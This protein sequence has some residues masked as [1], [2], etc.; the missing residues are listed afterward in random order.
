[1]PAELLNSEWIRGRGWWG[2]WPRAFVID[3]CDTD[4]G[5]K[6]V[7]INTLNSAGFYAGDVK[8]LVLA[9]EDMECQPAPT[10]RETG[11]GR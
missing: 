3:V 1:M 9:L 6:T 5:P 7:E 4:R 2:E 8:E 10:R 11:S